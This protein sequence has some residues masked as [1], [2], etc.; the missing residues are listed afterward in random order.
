M[1]AKETSIKGLFEVEIP[2]FVD[3]RGSVRELCKGSNLEAAGLP[4]FTV[5]QVNRTLSKQG[6]LRGIHAEDMQK[7]LH[8]VVGEVYAVIVD[9]REDSPTAGQHLGFTLTPGKGLFVSAGLG[10]AFQ[11]VSPEDS[12]Y[13]YMFDQEWTP[14]MPGKS[15]HPLDPTLA[16]EW[17][18]K[19]P[20]ISEKD[21]QNPPLAEVLPA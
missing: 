5:K 18:I 3:E 17:P 20:I 16:I 10:N 6:A 7:F 1:Q 9:L 14:N 21:Q 2:E 19:N 15:V 12:H 11:S 8:V 4:E 13:I